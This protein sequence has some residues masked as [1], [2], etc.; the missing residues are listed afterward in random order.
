MSGEGPSGTGPW[1]PT[2]TSK[3]T[4]LGWGTQK[5][6][7]LRRRLCHR[8]LTKLI[9]SK[10]RGVPSSIADGRGRPSLHRFVYSSRS[11]LQRELASHILHRRLTRGESTLQLCVLDCCQHFFEAG[12]GLVAGF[13]QVAAGD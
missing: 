7:T 1:N 12:T 8:Y 9:L 2:L 13:D 11:K 4:T 5:L 6:G 10:K 3:S